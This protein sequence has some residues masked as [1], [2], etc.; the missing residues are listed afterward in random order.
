MRD[1]KKSWFAIGQVL[2]DFRMDRRTPQRG[3][4]SAAVA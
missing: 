3:Y 4:S 1:E 2:L